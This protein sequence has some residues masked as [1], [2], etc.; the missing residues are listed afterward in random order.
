MQ[1]LGVYKLTGNRLTGEKTKFT[2][3]YVWEYQ[4][5]GGVYMQKEKER[6]RKEFYGEKRGFQ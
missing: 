5:E 6:G 1:W 2:Y 3:I 4:A